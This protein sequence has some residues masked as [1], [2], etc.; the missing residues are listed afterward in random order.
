MTLTEL[1]YELRK[2]LRFKWLTLDHTGYVT[3]WMS[4]PK[5]KEDYEG[6]RKIWSKGNDPMQGICTYI[7]PNALN[8]K[9]DLEEYTD[10]VAGID[11]SKC[12]VEVE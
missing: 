12:I 2:T 9:L 11:Y 5:Y 3:L 4:R 7:F 8:A 10:Q 6:G 1:A